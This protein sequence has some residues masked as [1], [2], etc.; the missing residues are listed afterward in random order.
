MFRTTGNQSSRYGKWRNVADFESVWHRDWPVPKVADVRQSKVADCW[1]VEGHKN[2]VADV[3]LNHSI[4]QW[5]VRKLG[6]LDVNGYAKEKLKVMKNRNDRFLPSFWLIVH[7]SRR[8][9]SKGLKINRF[10]YRYYTGG[11]QTGLLYWLLRYVSLIQRL[12]G[13]FT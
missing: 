13:T 7:V 11:L 3:V 8:L 1:I 5:A 9:F 2:W 12:Y 4:W 6:S 10:Y